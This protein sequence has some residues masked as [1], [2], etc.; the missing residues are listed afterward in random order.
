MAARISGV[1]EFPSTRLG[2]S[3]FQIPRLAP[4][5]AKL[6]RFQDPDIAVQNPDFAP[7]PGIWE[8][9]DKIQIPNSGS[10]LSISAPAVLTLHPPQPPL[11]WTKVDP[12]R[13]PRRPLAC[14]CQKITQTVCREKLEPGRVLTEPGRV[15][16]AV[17][18][19]HGVS[20]RDRW[21]CVLPGWQL[22]VNVNVSINSQFTDSHRVGQI[23]VLFSRM[24]R[25]LRTS[26]PLTATH[27]VSGARAALGGL[28]PRR[29]SATT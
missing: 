27:G 1:H 25:L 26:L 29:P 2:P 28:A 8:L 3:R 12:P 20:P 4:D 18:A 22:N 16:T 13:L 7:L 17:C 19:F 23:F 15:L 14:S 6:D 5:F 10:A 24:R 9:K 11:R 21:L